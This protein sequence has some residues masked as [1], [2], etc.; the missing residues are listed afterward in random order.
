MGR[1]ERDHGVEGNQ[2]YLLR[3]KNGSRQDP[4]AKAPMHVLVNNYHKGGAGGLGYQRGVPPEY[5][6]SASVV[7][8]PEIAPGSFQRG[9]G[10]P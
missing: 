7:A 3:R 2:A 4:R 10:V 6:T 8:L 9:L 5:E 1:E